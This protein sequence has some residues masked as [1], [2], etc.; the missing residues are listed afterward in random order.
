[1]QSIPLPRVAPPAMPGAFADRAPPYSAE[2]EMSVLGGMLID[3]DAIV[4]SIEILDDTMFYREG[5]RRLYR[6][7]IRLW[8]RGEVIDAVT[9]A[10]R[11]AP[12]GR[13]KRFSPSYP[14]TSPRTIRRQV[15][16]SRSRS[17]P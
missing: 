16:R 15:P 6:A 4:K 11:I 1:M 8:E 7:M 9:L 3:G 12:S 14:G 13:T 17:A 10:Q 5:N 2:A